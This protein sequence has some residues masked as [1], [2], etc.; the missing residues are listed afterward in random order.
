M[1]TNR[2]R[3]RQTPFR[4]LQSG[5][6]AF[7]LG[8]DDEIAALEPVVRR[9]GLTPVVYTIDPPTLDVE[10]IVMDESI[11]ERVAA[12]AMAIICAD[13]SG[14]DRLPLLS[15]VDEALPHDALL[16]ASC[17]QAGANEQAAICE[18]GRRLVGFG[19]LGLLSGKAIVEIA[20]SY[21]TSDEMLEKAAGFFT[22]AGVET[23]TVADTPGLV[24]ARLLV[25]VV[26]EAATALADGVA[27]AEDID[28]AVQLG[29]GFPFGILHWADEIGIDRVL[30]AM[31]YLVQATHEERYRPAPLLRRLAQA[32]RI[33][34]KA[35]R[36]FFSY[37]AE[38]AAVSRSRSRSENDG[39]P[40]AP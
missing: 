36:G 22:S 32:G 33:G 10:I 20:G 27:S 9:A 26:N 34:K 40:T 28:T 17:T 18:H 11:A 24:L 3:P 1:P 35:G 30:L 23:H 7:L 25:P 38:A 37:P 39:T 13:V 15:F 14:D 6:A 5:P 31:E 29:A 21:S 4:T 2:N 8:A 12:C 19:P 16:L